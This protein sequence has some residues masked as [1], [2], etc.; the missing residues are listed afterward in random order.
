MEERAMY[1]HSQG[2]RLRGY[3]TTVH[4]FTMVFIYTLKQRLNMFYSLLVSL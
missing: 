1:T 3:M 2:K 4:L